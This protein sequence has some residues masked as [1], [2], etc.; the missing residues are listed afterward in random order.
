VTCT[1]TTPGAPEPGAG[2]ELTVTILDVSQTGVRLILGG[3]VEAGQVLELTLENV[4]LRKPVKA[5]AEVVWA[6]PANDGR[7]CVGARFRRPLSYA[8]VQVFTYT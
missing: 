6:V 3:A 8:D 4:M 2:P 7:H 5:A 1:V